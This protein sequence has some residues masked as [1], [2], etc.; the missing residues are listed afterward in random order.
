LFVKYNI[1]EPPKW[2]YIERKERLY[3]SAY[4]C[5][6]L[7]FLYYITIQLPVL[8]NNTKLM[9]SQKDYYKL[10]GVDESAS[11]EEIKKAFKKLAV[12]YHPDKKG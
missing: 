4:I 9:A 2:Q 7:V 10:L 6:K 1:I 3:L 12:Q 8:F 11:P 5:K